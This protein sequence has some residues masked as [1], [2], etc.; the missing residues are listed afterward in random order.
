MPHCILHNNLGFG[1][2]A[3]VTSRMDTFVSEVV[4]KWQGS[5]DD[6]AVPIEPP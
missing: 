6:C 1:R 3:F 2:A 5:T 4:S